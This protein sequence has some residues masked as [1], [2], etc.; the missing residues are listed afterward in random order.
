MKKIILILVSIM[1]LF[2]GCKEDKA[3]E[4]CVNMT[5]EFVQ[6]FRDKDFESMYAMTKYQEPYL[7]GTYDKDSPIGTKLFDAM[8]NKLEFN[9]TSGSRDG[10]NA[11]VKAHIKTIDFNLVLTNV[12]KEYTD[13]CKSKGNSLTSEDMD[14]ALSS[15]LDTNINN[16]PVYEKDTSFDF[17]KEKGKW[18]IEDNVGVYDDLSGGYISY[19]FSLNYLSANNGKDNQ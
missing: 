13:Y 18:I 8:S 2:T 7:A 16:A 5:N 4:E 10:S 15:I 9:I 1:L 6:Y 3:P 11:Y 19:C 17:V 14:K 12:V